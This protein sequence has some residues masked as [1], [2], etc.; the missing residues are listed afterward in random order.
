V[1]ER[2]SVGA[3]GA[4]GVRRA[5]G[6][7]GAVT[8]Y[9]SA[10]KNERIPFKEQLCAIC[11]LR[12][13]KSHPAVLVEL[14]H[15]IS[16]WLCPLH[17]SDTF[18][19]MRAGRDF[20]E[21]M[22]RVWSAAGCFTKS[23]SQALD[24]H[25]ARLERRRSRRDEATLPGSYHWKALR[26]E[27]EH[28]AAQGESMQSIVGDLRARHAHD[29]ADVPSARTIRRWY[30]ERRWQRGIRTRLRCGFRQRDLRRASSAQRERAHIARLRGEAPARRPRPPTAGP[31]P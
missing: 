16:V 10:Y 28:R 19:S 14:T 30:S 11:T 4:S 27:T 21:T 5:G 22:R 13:R 8:Y 7:L 23:R 20:V 3:N 12:T 9:P 26:N 2:H 1:R 25:L 31:A 15:G 6:M 29:H 18:V 17:A 24:A